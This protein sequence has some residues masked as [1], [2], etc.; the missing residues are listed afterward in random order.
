ME[1]LWNQ[2][3]A[4][5]QQQRQQT[6]PLGYSDSKSP[7]Q[8]GPE[9]INMQMPGGMS[10]HRNSTDMVG[11]PYLPYNQQVPR[12]LFP[13]VRAATPHAPS[14]VDINIASSTSSPTTAPINLAPAGAVTA[15]TS[16]QAGSLPGPRNLPLGSSGRFSEGFDHN[17]ITQMIAAQQ[18]KSAQKNFSKSPSQVWNMV[19]VTI[20][21]TCN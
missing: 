14:P 17:L 16:P 9:S 21:T 3:S 18:Q 10:Y 1:A 11:M 12:N 15:N 7:S 13:N 20:L 2:R 5:Q 8:R 4:L 19:F 6:T